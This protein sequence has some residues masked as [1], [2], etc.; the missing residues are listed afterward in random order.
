V[1]LKFKRKLAKL[2]LI[3]S[4]APATNDL[5]LPSRL[6]PR[7]QLSAT[8]HHSTSSHKGSFVFNHPRYYFE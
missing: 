2:Q 5:H 3:P 4:S 8:P 1:D 6:N 7:L